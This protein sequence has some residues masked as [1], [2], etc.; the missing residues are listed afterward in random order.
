MIKT[1]SKPRSSCPIN[2]GLEIF[3][4]KW[5][6]LVLR[7]MLMIGKTTFKEFQAS[8]E[9]I[10]SN[11]LSDRLLRMEN[12][13]LITKHF[14]TQ[15]GRQT[16]YR[17]TQAGRK[18]LPVLVEMSYWGAKHDPKTG[19]PKSFVAAYESNRNGLLQALASGYDPSKN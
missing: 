16:N 2:F 6:L 10:A 9:R 11:I 13:G 19:A 7:D 1:P 12:C 3:G 14:S 5:S 17:I 15:D 8:E 4:D 18:L